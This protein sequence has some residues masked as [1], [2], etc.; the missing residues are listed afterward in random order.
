MKWDPD[1]LAENNMITNIPRSSAA[2]QLFD[3]VKSDLFIAKSMKYYNFWF[4][5]TI[6]CKQQWN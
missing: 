4:K 2:S 5:L 3:K 6:T 1:I